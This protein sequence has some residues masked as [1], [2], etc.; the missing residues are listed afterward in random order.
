M[1]MDLNQPKV[2]IVIVN[3]NG[4]EDTSE[5]LKSLSKISYSNF[6]IVIVDNNS[7]ND[8][9][10]KLEKSGQAKTHIIKCKENLGFAGGNN[11]GIKYSLEQKADYILLLNNDTKVNPDFLEILVS[12]YE[13]TDKAGIVAPRI[14]YFDVPQKIWSDG[15]YISRLRGSGFAYSDKLET[16][17]DNS[18]KSVT[19]VSG[20]CMLI[21]RDVSNKVGLFDENYFLYTEDTDLCQ[22]IIKAGY[23]IFVSPRS[24]IYHKVSNSSK[25]RYSALPLYYT[26]RNRLYFAKKNFSK[27]YFL[28]VAYILS[29]M[30]LKSIYWFASGKSKNVIAV[31]KSFK[32]FFSGRMGKIKDENYFVLPNTN[33]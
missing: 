10:E 28:T 12:K 7:A 27:I 14:N 31:T 33:T 5:L 17:V 30:I 21:S 15:G 18:D 22:R 16:E 2:N 8:E 25:T 4:L 9:A 1:I 32:D 20:C 3:W 24:K 29:A 13:S 11:I 23:K 19:F 6:F 26:T